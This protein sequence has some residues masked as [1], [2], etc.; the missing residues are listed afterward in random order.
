M[1]A[2]VANPPISHANLLVPGRQIVSCDT[3]ISDL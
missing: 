3:V 1:A 2:S